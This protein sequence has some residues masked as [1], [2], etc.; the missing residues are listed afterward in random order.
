MPVLGRVHERVL[1][2]RRTADVTDRLLSTARTTSL[3]QSHLRSLKGYDEPETLSC[4]IKS[5]RPIGADG[6]HSMTTGNV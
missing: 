1:A 2:P 6:R 4:A 5:I 3:F